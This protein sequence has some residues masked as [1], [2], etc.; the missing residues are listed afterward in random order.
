MKGTD[1]LRTYVQAHRKRVLLAGIVALSVLPICL[2][3]LTGISTLVWAVP[4]W[5]LSFM[6]GSKWEAHW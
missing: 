1:R 3:V 5:P 2:W 6:I 4:L